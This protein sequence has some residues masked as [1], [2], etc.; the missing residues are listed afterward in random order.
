M[1]L[2][3]VYQIFI[4]LL[5]ILSAFFS[6]SETA[7]ISANRY[8]I[9]DGLQKGQFGA[10]NALYIINNSERAISM[11]L[12]G[13]NIANIITTSFVT[14]IANFYFKAT[15]FQLLL[16][17]TVQTLVFLL[18]CEILPKIFSRVNADKLLRILSYPLYYLMIIFSPLLYFTQ[19]I[20]NRVKK[21]LSVNE[22]VNYRN[23][24]RTEIETLFQMGESAGLL[25]Q[26]HRI[27]VDE[28]LSMH[29]IRVNQVMTPTIEITSVEIKSSIRS[30]IKLIDKT[31]F[32]RIP[33]YEDRVDNIIGYVYYKDL[34]DPDVINKSIS[35]ILRK[36]YFIPETKK[37]Y[38]LYRLM[39]SENIH[40]VFVVNEFGAVSGLAS[41]EDIAEEIVGE[42]QTTDHINDELMISRGKNS[43]S[44][45]GT[46]DIEYFCRLFSVSIHKDGFETVGGFSTSFL[47]RIPS[48]GER[49]YTQGLTFEIESASDKAIDRILISRGKKIAR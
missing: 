41:R 6:G 21:I 2:L 42:I 12:I 30:L 25:E 35:D 29:K 24:A 3:L 23:R 1:M 38:E 17:I 15:N 43:F 39:K 8:A 16:V 5:V 31:R 49:F 13:N 28:I 36:T 10:K 37:I 11:I 19:I 26:N 22:S 27:Y 34:Y 9:E 45:K 33:I 32:S 46:L 47:G 40:I 20:T 48:I 4:F 14:F 7:I 44:V 18:F